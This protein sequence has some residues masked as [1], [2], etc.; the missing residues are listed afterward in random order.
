MNAGAHCKPP[1]SR[2]FENAGFTLLE[3]LI[4]VALLGLIA[5]AL[6][7]GLRFSTRS[8]EA[9]QGNSERIEESLVVQHLLRSYLKAMWPLRQSQS[10]G[11]PGAKFE[12]RTDRLRFVSLMH[13]GTETD[14]PYVF[15]LS[16][17]P[18][19]DRRSLML[20]WWRYHS[21]DDELYS[22]TPLGQR[23]LLSPVE[24]VSFRFLA[25]EKSENG[26]N[27]Q[28]LWDKTDRLPRL[29]SIE[30]ST[31]LSVGGVLPRMMIAPRAVS[32]SVSP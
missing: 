25:H 15:E 31:P 23:E 12:G 27:W 13:R 2:D 24:A 4:V 30:V 7:G 19:L 11:E 1:S 20:K 32:A 28:E 3:L 8:W 5:T 18:R 6:F 16:A 10:S 26:E 17:A 22:A 9:V 14:G 29:I 21:A